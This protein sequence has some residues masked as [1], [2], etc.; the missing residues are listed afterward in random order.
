MK[1]H[2]ISVILNIII[3]I[4]T[5]PKKEAIT[6]ILLGV[7]TAVNVCTSSDFKFVVVL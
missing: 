6:N 7:I 4:V 3:T 1:R 2:I 5:D